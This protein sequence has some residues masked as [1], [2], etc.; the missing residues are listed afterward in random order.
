[1]QASACLPTRLFA[2]AFALVLAYPTCLALPALLSNTTQ[3]SAS[4][5]SAALAQSCRAGTEPQL[6]AYLLYYLFITC[7]IL[8]SPALYFLTFVLILD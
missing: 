1:V 2:F 3:L 6:S 8:Y 4:L 5:A 7:Y